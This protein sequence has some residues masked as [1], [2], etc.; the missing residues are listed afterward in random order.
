MT[1]QGSLQAGVT[2]LAALCWPWPSL[3]AGPLAMLALSFVFVGWV[4]VDEG[5]T[6]RLKR[7]L[8]AVSGKQGGA[9]SS[10]AADRGGDTRNSD[11]GVVASQE[12][13]HD[14]DRS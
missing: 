4:I 9:E 6:N 11:D 14:Q 5:R 7:L 2:A 1:G 12:G 8:R 13:T 10:T 3:V